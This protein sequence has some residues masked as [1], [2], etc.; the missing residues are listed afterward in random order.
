MPPSKTSFVTV[1][2][3]VL[4][5]GVV[6]AALTPAASVVSLDVV[7]ETPAA[8]TGAGPG[9]PAADLAAYSRAAVTP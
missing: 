5:L 3:Q 2:Q 9:D 7:R 4:A 1:C 6:V 8:G